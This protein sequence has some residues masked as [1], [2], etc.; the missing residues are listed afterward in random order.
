MVQTSSKS[1]TSLTNR[2]LQS[3][4]HVLSFKGAVLQEKVNSCI[5]THLMQKKS[6]EM[7]HRKKKFKPG[8]V[9]KAIEVRRDKYS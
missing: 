3:K 1:Q 4:L 9:Q 2:K 5:T 7:S 8:K 6:F